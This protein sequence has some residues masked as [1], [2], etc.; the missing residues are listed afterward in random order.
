MIFDRKKIQKSFCTWMR[1][2]N[3]RIHFPSVNSSVKNLEDNK[4]IVSIE[5]PEGDIEVAIDEAF[6]K[7]SK[8]VK[9]PGFRQGK[10]PRKVLEAKFGKEYA[11]SEALNDIVGEVYFQAINEH[12]LDVIAQP[13]LELIAGQESG[14]A[15]FEATVEVRPTIEIQ[16]YKNLEIE[17]PSP[18]VTQEEIDESVNRLLEQASERNEVSRPATTGDFI[19]MDLSG[20]INGEPEESL[21]AEGFVFEIGSSFIIE[22]INASLEGAE[23]GQE[24][25][26]GGPHPSEEDTELGFVAKILSIEEKILP[27]LTDELAAELSEFETVDLLVADTKERMEEMKRNQLPGQATSKMLE[28]ISELVTEEVPEPLIQEQIQQQV[29]DMAM[30]MAQQ[31]MQFEQFLQ[32]TNQSMEDIVSNLREPSEQA[33]RTDLALRAVAV[34]EAIEVTES[35]VENEIENVAKQYALQAAIQAEEIDYSLEMTSEEIDAQLSPRIE[36]EKE[37]LTNSLQENGQIR[38]L[39]ADLLK[40]KALKL[41]EDSVKIKDEDGNEIDKK[42]IFVEN[43]ENT[44]ELSQNGSNPD[45][46]DPKEEELSESDD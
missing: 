25:E 22:E 18:H 46:P 15:T 2:L 4:V 6:K 43:T 23:I 29:Q 45:N 20:A 30:R 38:I 19:T 33:V 37:N 28:A 31:G 5:V 36:T 12:E 42:E 40:Q 41:V 14:A 24:I 17:V 16:G 11:R 32:A 13:Q 9:L 39:K 35:D 26:F 44:S 21:T 1:A 7:I 10:A 3:K 27:E 34:A 8:E